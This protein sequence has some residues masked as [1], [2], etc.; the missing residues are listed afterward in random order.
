MVWELIIPVLL[1]ST[2][3][4]LC[5]PTVQKLLHLVAGVNTSHETA[6]TRM[7]AQRFLQ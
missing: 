6:Y 1:L 4:S 7:L 2:H 3:N 5:T